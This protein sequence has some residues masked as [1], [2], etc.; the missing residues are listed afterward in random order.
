MIVIY[1]VDSAI[2]RSNNFCR[3]FSYKTSL[4]ADCSVRT[5]KRQIEIWSNIS[6]MYFNWK[7]FTFSF[8]V[9]PG[10]QGQWPYDVIVVNVF[11]RRFL[12]LLHKNDLLAPTIQLI[13]E[14]KLASE[15]A[16]R[17]ALAARREKEGKLATTSLELNSCIKKVDAKCWLAE[18]TCVMTSLPLTRVFQCLF[19]SALVRACWLV[20]IWQ[21]SR[22]GATGNWRWNSNSRDV[23]ASSPSFPAP[24][25]EHPGELTRR[26]KQIAKR[27]FSYPCTVPFPSPHIWQ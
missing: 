1:P 25:P 16:L 13:L 7:F 22:R 8:F 5:L 20:E 6:T 27:K 17:G 3:A 9:L 21:L 12:I 19:T 23:V 2:H 18:M 26:L 4:L 24:S 10:P 15:Q 11:L 14:A